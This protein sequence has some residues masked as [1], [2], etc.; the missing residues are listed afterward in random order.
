MMVVLMTPVIS[1]VGT[2]AFLIHV[3]M[4]KM[5]TNIEKKHYHVGK[6]LP[7]SV[8]YGTQILHFN[9]LIFGLE[10]LSLVE[11]TV[12]HFQDH[13]QEIDALQQSCIIYIYFFFPA[14]LNSADTTSDECTCYFLLIFKIY[15]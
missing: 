6:K 12:V 3:G 11:N 8:L 9:A 2:T 4:Q 1:R 10:H 15:C 5:F 13:R 7:M 14:D